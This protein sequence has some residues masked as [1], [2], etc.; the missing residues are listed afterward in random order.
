MLCLYFSSG[1]P[2]NVQEPMLN[3]LLLKNGEAKST[4]NFHAINVTK[5]DTTLHVIVRPEFSQST[6][7]FDILIQVSNSQVEGCWLKNNSNDSK[8]IDSLGNQLSDVSTEYANIIK[9]TK[10]R[11]RNNIRRSK[12][13]HHINFEKCLEQDYI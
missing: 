7:L 9:R 6:D 10:C 3:T 4:M 13:F 12:Y 1:N 8:S 2:E 11:I 5:N